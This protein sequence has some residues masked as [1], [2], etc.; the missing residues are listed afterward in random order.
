MKFKWDGV[1]K[2]GFNIAKEMFEELEN[3]DKA[4][5]GI[6]VNVYDR[7]YNIHEIYVLMKSMPKYTL[8]SCMLGFNKIHVMLN[9]DNDLIVV[10][11]KNTIEYLKMA[12]TTS[13]VYADYLHENCSDLAFLDM[14]FKLIKPKEKK[15]IPVKYAQEALE[16]YYTNKRSIR[17]ISSIGNEFMQSTYKYTTF[18]YDEES[19]PE[20]ECVRDVLLNGDWEYLGEE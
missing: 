7:S 5:N 13:N 12:F 6:E 15:W 9:E 16:Q 17:H 1:T 19:C 18:E 3:L 10:E 14:T 11:G 8:A 4:M 20:E 2:V